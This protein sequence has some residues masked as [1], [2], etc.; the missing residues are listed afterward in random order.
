M[1]LKR[2]TARPPAR[3]S[4]ATPFRL[5][6]FYYGI[7]LFVS[8]LFALVFAR[9]QRSRWDGSLFLGIGTG[10]AADEI[11]LLF[12]GIPYSHPL[13]ILVLAILASMFCVGT[14]H[15]SVRDGTKEFGTLDHSDVLTVMAVLLGV[16][17]VLY[18]D[19]PQ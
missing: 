2:H 12:L 17:G 14:L 11:G 3:V 9:R 13:A 18:L 19:R 16:S 8:S 4:P 5:H 1:Q 6:H 10:L 7:G 15:A